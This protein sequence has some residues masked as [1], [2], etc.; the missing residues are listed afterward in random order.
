[1]DTPILD[2][3]RKYGDSGFTRFHMPGHK[4]SGEMGCERWDVT[5]IHG[6]DS[7]YEA[8]GI[9][10]KSEENA[11]RLFGSR[12]TCYSTEGSSQCIRA[13]LYLALSGRP[14]GSSRMV[15]TARNVHRSFVYA[16][17]LLDIEPVWLWPKSCGSLCTCRI[18]AEELEKAIASEKEPPAAV[19][20]TSPDYLGETAD[21]AAMADVCHKNGTLLIVDN[22]HGAYLKFLPESDH[23]LDL[24]ADMCCDS[25]HKTLPVLTGGAYL[26]ISSGLNEKY[27]EQAK[28]ALALFGSTSPSYLILASL[29]A[30]NS[31]LAGEYRERLG[32]WVKEINGLKERLR[33]AGWG[34]AESDPLRLVIKATKRHSGTAIAAMLRGNCIECEYADSDFAVLMTT[35][36]NTA[37]DIKGLEAAL[38]RCAEAVAKQVPLPQVRAEQVVSVREAFFLPHEKIPINK[39][40]GRICGAP[41]VSCPPAI[42]IAVSGERIGREA[43]ALFKRYGIKSVEVV[44]P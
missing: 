15:I 30:C 34:I 3:V 24:G 31:L 9:I 16:A 17:A 8:E 40:E 33:A 26:H 21:I 12:R 36:D 18:T 32:T 10:A 43:I 7:L 2:F 6:A 38:G 27:A 39:A 37:E 42:P 13:M 20:I 22:A 23:P 44:K 5:E 41:A 25:A 19:Y 28:A 14:K 4:G 29:D 1:M 35:P 11:A